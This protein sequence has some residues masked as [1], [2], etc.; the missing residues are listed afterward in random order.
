M[1]PSAIFFQPES[2]NG[3]SNATNHEHNRIGTRK[4]K[5]GMPVSSK[6]NVEKTF[7]LVLF[8]PGSCFVRLNEYFFL[9]FSREGIYI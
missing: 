2:M 5:S 3:N 8:L 1:Q 4:K 6:H 7:L 9:D